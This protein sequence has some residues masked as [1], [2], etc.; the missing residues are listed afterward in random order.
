MARIIAKQRLFVFTFA[1]TALNFCGVY[2]LRASE[3]K[4]SAVAAEETPELKVEHAECTWFGPKREQL[5][6][7]TLHKYALTATTDQVTRMM[8]L[9]RGVRP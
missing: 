4:A 2:V 3:T 7:E 8:L 6:K 9:G 1:A 5:A